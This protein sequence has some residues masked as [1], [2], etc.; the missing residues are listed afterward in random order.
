MID[1]G[2][3]AG[4]VA[5]VTGAAQGIGAHYA[6][7]LAAQGAAVVVIDVLDTGAVC[8]EIMAAG[9]RAIALKGRALEDRPRCLQSLNNESRE[10][11]SATARGS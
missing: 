2:R 7:A 1:V 5:T 9:G 11:D 6:K 4:R 3:L 10:N 8:E